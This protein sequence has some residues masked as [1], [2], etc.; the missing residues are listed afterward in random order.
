MKTKIQIIDIFK[1]SRLQYETNLHV[2]KMHPFTLI[3][4]HQKVI[5]AHY[6]DLEPPPP[7]FWTQIY[8]NVF[9]QPLT[10][11]NALFVNELLPCA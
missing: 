7:I 9:G 10:Q 1:S 4:L 8:T 11:N 3:T 2:N 5:S 6:P